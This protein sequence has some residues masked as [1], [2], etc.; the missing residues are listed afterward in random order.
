MESTRLG[1]PIASGSALEKRKV[2]GDKAPSILGGQI[3]GVF[4]PLRTASENAAKKERVGRAR[5]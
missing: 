5:A 3:Y 2:L 1:E 4:C